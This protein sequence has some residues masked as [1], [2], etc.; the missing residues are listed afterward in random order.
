MSKKGT[1][2]SGR[3]RLPPGQIS[4]VAFCAGT[5]GSLHPQMAAIG[6][7]P[8]PSQSV[9]F[10][11]RICELN[12]PHVRPPGRTVSKRGGSPPSPHK[13]QVGSKPGHPQKICRK[14][15][16]LTTAFSHETGSK[17][18]TVSSSPEHVLTELGRRPRASDTGLPSRQMV[19][20]P[21][22]ESSPM[23][24]RGTQSPHNTLSWAWKSVLQDSGSL[25]KS[26]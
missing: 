25:M 11:A 15:S 7:E 13:V 8:I 5:T 21:W 17:G 23:L 2:A 19:Q 22:L 24:F 10:A 18:E 26:C 14:L 4:H 3:V 1:V 16:S 9:L 12:S 6:R 20:L